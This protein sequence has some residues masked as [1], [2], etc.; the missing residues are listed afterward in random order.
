MR[1]EEGHLGS[2]GSPRL[3]VRKEMR[4]LFYICKELD[5]TNNSS[6][7]TSGLF[8]SLQIRVQ[9]VDAFISPVFLSCITVKSYVGIDVSC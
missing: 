9:L 3:A 8:Q 6:G 1:T 5:S 7:L 2:K 4:T